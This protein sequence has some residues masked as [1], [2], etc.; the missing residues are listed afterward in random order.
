MILFYIWKLLILVL[1]PQSKSAENI[2]Q[3]EQRKN[4]VD[5]RERGSCEVRQERGGIFQK[6]QQQ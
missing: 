2:I 1:Y 3:I 4:F 5:L 6:I